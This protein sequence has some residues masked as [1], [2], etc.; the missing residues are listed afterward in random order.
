MTGQIIIDGD[1]HQTRD[2]VF[3]DDLC[4]AIQLAL[5]CDISGEVFQIATGLETSILQLANLMRETTG[6]QVALTH[7]AARQGDIRE[8]YALIAKVQVGLG[9]R[10]LTQLKQGLDITWKWMRTRL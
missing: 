4:R 8:N 7:A 3:V 1:G 10:P 6:R 9:W 2:F 5:R